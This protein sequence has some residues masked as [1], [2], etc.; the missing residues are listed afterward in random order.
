[1]MNY[2]TL[3]EKSAAFYNARPKAKRAL[4]VTN[5][6]LTAV[7]FLAYIALILW[8]LIGKFPVWDCVKILG[9]PALCLVLVIILRL[10][11]DRPRPYSAAGASIEPL[12]YKKSK[13]KES[14]PSRHLA[15][16]FVIAAVFAPYLLWV[17]LT[18]AALGFLLGYVRFA[19]GVHYPSDLLGGAGLGMLCGLLLLI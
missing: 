2:K 10:M 5:L 11:I 7:F 14:F 9:I 1:M 8:A 18:L 12:F 13:D 19:L 17:S 4:Y 15:C 3:Y 16:A 6:A